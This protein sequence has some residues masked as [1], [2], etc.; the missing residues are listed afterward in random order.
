ME[1]EEVHYYYYYI[2]QTNK[3]ASKQTNRAKQREYEFGDATRRVLGFGH[4]T[5]KSRGRQAA[6]RRRKEEARRRRRR[7][8]A[9]AQDVRMC[10]RGCVSEGDTTQ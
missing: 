2:I 10:A 1:E 3:Q 5:A 4:C 6:E 7:R 9:V 8:D